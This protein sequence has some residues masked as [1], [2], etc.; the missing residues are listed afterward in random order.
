[1]GITV[2]WRQLQG[3]PSLPAVWKALLDHEHHDAVGT[4]A[5]SVHGCCSNSAVAEAVLHDRHQL[6][7][8]PHSCLM[9]VRQVYAS[10]AILLYL[11]RDAMVAVWGKP[12]LIISRL[13][14]ASASGLQLLA[15]LGGLPSAS[16]G[17]QNATFKARAVGAARNQDDSLPASMADDRGCQFS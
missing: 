14:L 13:H 16:F 3:M 12:W 1:M 6:R 2:R 5:A 4:A 8:A 9:R 17:S 7:L 11:C 10:D 15:S